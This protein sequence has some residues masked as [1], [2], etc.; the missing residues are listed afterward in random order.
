[1]DSW[2]RRH[3]VFVTALSGALYEVAGDPYAFP[4][5]APGFEFILAI[6]EG[7]EAMD[8]HAI[9]SA[10]LAL[11]AILERG[12]FPIAAAY[13]KRLLDSPRGEYYF[14]RHARRAATEMSALAGDILVLLCDDAV[15]RLRRLYASID[16][17]A[18]TTRQPDRQAR[19]RP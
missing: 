7:W 6:R 13:W 1:M 3:A 11:C 14:A 10:P 17:V 16:R 12:P 18:A 19:P 5:I 4:R 15:P 9:G 8:W 2:L